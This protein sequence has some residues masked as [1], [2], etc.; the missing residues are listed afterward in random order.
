MLTQVHVIS[1]VFTLAIVTVVG[2]Y[3]IRQVKTSADFAVGGRS[4]GV[5]LVAGTIM[6]TVVGGASTI[7]TAQLAFK[8]GF[9]AWWFTLGAG[10]ACLLLGV[11]AKPLRESGASTAPQFLVKAYGERAGPVASVFSSLGIFLNII[12]Q[13]LSAVALLTSMFQ[14]PPLLAAFIAVV[15]V[16]SYVIFGGVWGTGM[17]GV[18][19]LILLYISLAVA[20]ILSYQMIGGLPGLTATFPA[21]PWFSLFGRGFNTDAAAGFSLVVGVLSTQTYLQAMFSGR[22][23]RT[24]RR[25]ALVSALLI[26]P[27]GLASIMVGLYMRSHFPEIDPRE[28]LPLFILQFLNPWVGGMVLA[29]LLLSVVGTGA[30]LTLGIS[31]MLSQDIYKKIINPKATDSGVLAVTRVIIIVVTLA[32]LVFVG[33]NLNS[34]ILKWSF[35]SMGLRGATI[36]FPLLAAIFLRNKIAAW[37]GRWAII[38]GPSAVLLWTL[39]GGALDPLYVGMA[40]SLLLLVIGYFS[41]KA[42]S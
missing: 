3:S 36:C 40:C 30:G 26:P 18:V 12:G 39:L 6:G 37:A 25:G 41:R 42:F 4:M 35:L 5:S 34:L 21:F 33:G 11:L 32:T 31:T 22:D 1:M 19:K 27:I 23:V 16:I 15:L 2:V 14:V 10:I 38:A 17:V 7:G 13:I 20:G 8:V 9:S 24:S 29:T 28:A